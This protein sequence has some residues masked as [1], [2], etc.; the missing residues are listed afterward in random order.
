[1]G[2]A[3][4]KGITL[5]FEHKWKFVLMLI[6]AVGFAA[7]LF[8]FGD[9]GDLVTSQ[10]S[11]VT[12]NRLYLQFDRLHLSLF[13]EAGI[14]LDEVYLEAQNFPSLK[15]QKLI[16]TPSISSLIYQK[17]AGS[18]TLKG[19]LEGTVEASLKPASKSDNGVP[20]QA[21]TLHAKKL[22]L[23]DLRELAE[24]PVMIKGQLDIDSQAI[25]DL[26]FQEAPDMDLTIKI[27][28][29]EL[30]A[31]N[32]QTPMGPL[33]LPNLKLSSVEL[34]GRLSA[35][36]FQIESGIIGRDADEVKG[37]IKGGMALTIQ[38]RNG[39]I[40][41]LWGAYSFD[42]DLS[43]RKSFQDRAALF[44]SF[45]D[46]HKTPLADGSRYAFKISA[47]DPQLPPSVTAL[48]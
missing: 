4:K 45:I 40:I 20:R 44:L 10:V 32:V 3:V 31:A 46:Q 22:S 13:P 7:F 41:P 23:S 30:P 43:I 24:L 26:S 21:L 8:P 28:K 34:K 33:T 15:S 48:H 27:E 29:F 17:P 18:V 39:Q 1:M 38:N 5:L 2:D 37:T 16:F 47:N 25:A 12:N 35:G 14:A 19:F 36:R 11:K 9:L 6:S 42:I